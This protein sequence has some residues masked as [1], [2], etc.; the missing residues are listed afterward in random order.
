MLV[1][2]FKYFLKW[3]DDLATSIYHTFVALCYLTPILGAIVADSWLGKFKWAIVPLVPLIY[4]GGL[5]CANAVMF[6]SFLSCRTII[7]LS[8]VYAL[9]QVAMAVSAIHDI[10]DSDKDGVPN[11]MTFHV[12][13]SADLGKSK[14][15]KFGQSFLISYIELPC[16]SSHP[17][18]C[19][20][21]VCSSLLWAQVA[22]NLVWLPLVETS[23]MNTRL[24]SDLSSAL[25]YTESFTWPMSTILSTAMVVGLRGCAQNI[26]VFADAMFSMFS[27][28]V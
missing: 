12:W 4:A 15:I 8:I 16:S 10:T 19:P 11:N 3:D 6:V 7:Y 23:S 2:Y 5:N 1:L 21:W 27:I 28:M 24:D 26:L 14:D 25:S 17:V 18:R 20:W 22:S 13:V 9:G